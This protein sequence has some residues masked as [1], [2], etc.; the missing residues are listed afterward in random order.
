MEITI[1]QWLRMEAGYKAS[2]TGKLITVYALQFS[3]GHMV[4]PEAY[5]CKVDNSQQHLFNSSFNARQIEIV[6]QE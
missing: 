6:E 2:G 5:F 1:H 3:R 4:K